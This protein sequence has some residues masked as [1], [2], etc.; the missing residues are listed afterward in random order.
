MSEEVRVISADKDGADLRRERRKSSQ[1][2]RCDGTA[3]EVQVNEALRGVT[4]GKVWAM[5]S[6]AWSRI[7]GSN[8]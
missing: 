5:P 4:K 1:Y 3:D 2:V 6:E 8:D 7:F